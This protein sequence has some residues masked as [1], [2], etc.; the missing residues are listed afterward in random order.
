MIL[1]IL[2]HIDKRTVDGVERD[3]FKPLTKIYS[4]LL[5]IRFE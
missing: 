4:N 1:D 3:G 5:I 2:C